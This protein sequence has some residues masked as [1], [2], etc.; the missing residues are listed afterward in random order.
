MNLKFVANSLLKPK[1]R[2]KYLLQVED[3]EAL[4]WISNVESSLV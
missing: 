4:D 2:E 3:P 1:K